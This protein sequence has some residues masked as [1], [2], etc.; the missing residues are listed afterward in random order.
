MSDALATWIDGR[1]ADLVPVADRGLHYGDGL[2]ET[3]LVRQGRPRFLEL[4]LARLALGC[5]RLRLPFQSMKELRADIEAAIA[6][7]SALAILKII[8]TRGSAVQRGYAPGGETPRR[9]V[10]LFD[11]PGPTNPAEGVVLALAS[12]P[13]PDNPL[14]AGI[15]HLNRLDNVL[16][17]HEARH[18]GAFDALMTGSDGRVVSGAMSNCFVV[19]GGV[20]LT[21]PLDRAGVAG[22]MRAVVIRESPSLGLAVTERPL[23]MAELRIADEV[24]I[25]NVRIGVVP[26]R[27]VGEHA[28]RMDLISRRIA[29]HVD[30]LDA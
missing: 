22:V 3:V 27:R 8:V 18:A 30:T 7:A 5:E 12:R 25:T 6:Q 17:T 1:R 29:R 21:P 4:H 26:V 28:F 23:A 9:I 24:F 13:L 14:L 19:A 11:C 20:L 15:K 16:A 10:M 2:F